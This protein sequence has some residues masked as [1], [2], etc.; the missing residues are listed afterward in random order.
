MLADRL[1]MPIKDV[2][3]LSVLELDLW[4]AWIKKQ[5]DYAN[6]Q[7]RRQRASGYKTKNRP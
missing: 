4:S 2:M 6:Q 5:Q 3:E 7:M 1:K